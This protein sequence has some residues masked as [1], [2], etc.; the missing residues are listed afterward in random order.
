MVEK[1]KLVKIQFWSGEKMRKEIKE[2]AHGIGLSASDFYKGGALLL[3]NLLKNPSEVNLN[4]FTRSF[5]DFENNQ[6]KKKI[7]KSFSGS[8]NVY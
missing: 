7:Q 1:E 4:L 5:K 8:R 3:I 6:I 2:F